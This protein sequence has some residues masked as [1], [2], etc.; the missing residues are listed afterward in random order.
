MR[1]LSQSEA[2]IQNEHCK[3]FPLS[4]YRSPR[5][6]FDSDGEPYSE[7]DV[8]S[9]SEPY[10]ER[11]WYLPGCAAALGDLLCLR[12]RPKGRCHDEQ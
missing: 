6:D 10:T 1:L 2:S 4:V 3:V 12:S 7:P 11:R 8:D 9:D 5:S